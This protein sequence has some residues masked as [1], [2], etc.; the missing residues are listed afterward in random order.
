[1]SY[2][3]GIFH[4]CSQPPTDGHDEPQVHK[5]VFSDH[6]IAIVGYGTD[7]DG[8]DY[9]IVR[10]SWGEQFGKI[11]SPFPSPSPSPIPIPIPVPVQARTATSVYHEAVMSA[12]LK[13]LQ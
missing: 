9:Y 6:A 3:S 1:M 10:N 7:D 8:N 12:V 13:V 11:P 5:W 2:E 4:G